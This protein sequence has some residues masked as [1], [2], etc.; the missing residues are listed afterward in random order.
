MSSP[1]K[2]S[3]FVSPGVLSKEKG[4]SGIAWSCVGV[5]ID[6]ML[7]PILQGGAVYRRQGTSNK[8]DV[9]EQST[10]DFTW[11]R[12][13]CGGVGTLIDSLGRRGPRPSQYSVC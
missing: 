1:V 8:C 5:D 4:K 3:A 9:M 10:F 12:D 13:V 7:C 6:A 2:E 11:N